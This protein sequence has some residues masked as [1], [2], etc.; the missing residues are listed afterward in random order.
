MIAPCSE[1]LI[2]TSQENLALA[3]ILILNIFEIAQH[4]IM[5]CSNGIIVVSNIFTINITGIEVKTHGPSTSRAVPD[6]MI[7]TIAEFTFFSIINLIRITCI[8]RMSRCSWIGKR[9]L[10]HLVRFSPI[11]ILK[12]V[13]FRIMVTYKSEMLFA[14][15][16]FCY[17]SSRIALLNIIVNHICCL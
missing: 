3:F 2:S 5:I 8:S 15:T 4:Q 13:D 16:N 1:E 6:D 17:Y 10:S 7:F 11:S 12:P 9:S 14:I